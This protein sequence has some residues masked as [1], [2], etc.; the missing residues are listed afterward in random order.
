MITINLLPEE[1][2][3]KEKIKR[4]IPILKLAAISG[5]L[6]SAITIFLYI[7]YIGSGSKLKRLEKEW[8]TLQP[9]SQRLNHLEQEVETLL[10]PENSFLNRFV[11]AD[12]PVTLILSWVSELLPERA[13][14]LE[15]RLERE[16]EG[17]R[18]F[19]KGVALSSKEKSSIE[20]IESYLHMMKEKIPEASLSL[21]T[22]RLEIEKTEVTQFVANFEWGIQ[23]VKKP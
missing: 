5:V 16:G 15:T 2:R 10:K 18:L 8:V 20:Q 1:L 4:D 19:V 12:K 9:Q 23:A 17:A 21:T 13:W 7:D 14:L 22:T 6:F 3:V 11:T